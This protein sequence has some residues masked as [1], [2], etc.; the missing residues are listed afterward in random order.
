MYPT[1]RRAAWSIALVLVAVVLGAVFTVSPQGS[2]TTTAQFGEFNTATITPTS[3][4]PACPGL[5]LLPAPV[6]GKVAV[7]HR[8]GS[9]R[10][11]YV[12]IEISESALEAHQEHGDAN[13]RR[14]PTATPT[15]T[16]TPTPTPTPTATP[17]PTP[18]A[19]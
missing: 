9:D 6:E 1:N 5:G 2:S 4:P 8:T 11:P 13:F 10:D 3:T 14:A 19:G 18:I 7:C 17:T 12:I 15:R 16:P